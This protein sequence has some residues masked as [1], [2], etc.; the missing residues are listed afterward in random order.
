MMQL[1]LHALSPGGTRGRLSVLIFHRVLA[2]ADPL[3]PGECD[4]ARFAQLC[5]WARQLFNVIPLAD[6]VRRLRAGELPP[7]ALAITFDDGYADNYS[8]AQP[9]LR[10]N[11]LSA[12]FFV[13]TGFLNGG[14]MWN[15]TLIE[16]VRRTRRE[17]LDL[18]DAGIVGVES[19]VMDS[20]EARRT[21]VQALI[22]GCRYMLP[23]QR[24][25]A[26]QVVTRVADCSLPG[27]LMMND[28]QVRALHQAGMG[29]GGHT[30][31]HPILARLPADEARAEIAGGKTRLQ[32]ILQS[33]V[34]LFAYPNGR[35][36]DDFRTEHVAMVQELGFEAAFTTAW[37]CARVASDPFQ[38]PRFTPWDSKRWAF[39]LRM[40]RNLQH[41]V[42]LAAA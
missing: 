12:T 16:A 31:G 40:V 3:L 9:I 27:N 6:A 32:E 19:L 22:R 41:P 25:Q 18:E 4:A 34:S 15:D 39:G 17:R 2:E 20:L 38:M 5:G 13:A 37:G 14:R 28:D 36:D 7:R 11:G 33:G 10:A 8:I 35:P 29:I 26:V 30:V 24:Q 1:G 42:R 23:A 21:A